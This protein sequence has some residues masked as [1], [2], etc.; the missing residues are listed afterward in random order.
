MSP[1]LQLF[2]GM[3]IFMGTYYTLFYYMWVKPQYIDTGRDLPW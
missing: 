3:T 1:N 2:I